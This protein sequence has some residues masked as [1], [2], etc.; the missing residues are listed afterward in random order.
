M[1]KSRPENTWAVAGLHDNSTII[2]MES[3]HATTNRH[4]YPPMRPNEARLLHRLAPFIRSSRH[5]PFHLRDGG[6]C[7]RVIT[8]CE[9]ARCCRG[10]GPGPNGIHLCRQVVSCRNPRIHC[11]ATSIPGSGSRAVGLGKQKA[12]GNKTICNRGSVAIMTVQFRECVEMELI[13]MDGYRAKNEKK[14]GNLGGK[15]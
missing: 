11:R 9:P 8:C 3:L 6:R 14:G 12:K 7:Q 1:S 15:V 13:S 4:C 5:L 2:R 10:N